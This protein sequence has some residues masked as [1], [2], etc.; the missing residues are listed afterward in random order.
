MLVCVSIFIVERSH[1]DPII[2]YSGSA[3]S[4]TLGSEICKSPCINGRDIWFIL[5]PSVFRLVN[6]AETRLKLRSGECRLALA[7]FY[8]MLSQMVEK[9]RR[10]FLEPQWQARP[11]CHLNTILTIPFQRYV[12]DIGFDPS[13]L[14]TLKHMT[15]TV[16]WGCQ[17]D[18]VSISNVFLILTE[19]SFSCSSA[20]DTLECLRAADINDLQGINLEINA[21]GFFGTFVFV[22]V[23]DGSFITERPTELLKAGKVNGVRW[24]HLLLPEII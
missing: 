3:G 19:A 9:H 10:H 4:I 22:H 6:S 17:P 15:V 5:S 1:F 7:Q 18:E 24:L 23:V 2:Y 14:T 21:S 12:H 16:Q 11:S 20:Q 13:I 8:N